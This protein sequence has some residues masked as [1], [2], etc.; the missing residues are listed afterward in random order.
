MMLQAMVIGFILVFSLLI[1]AIS[2]IAIKRHNKQIDRRN[3]ALLR[4]LK[5]VR[6][7]HP[8][9]S[10]NRVKGVVEEYLSTGDS[11]R[12]EEIKGVYKDALKGEKK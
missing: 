12:D 3:D 7:T 1:L 4:T 6:K 10:F 11:K 5:E 8:Q 2:V 9:F